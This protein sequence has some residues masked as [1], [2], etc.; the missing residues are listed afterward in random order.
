MYHSLLYFNNSSFVFLQ[1]I[2]F[3]YTSQNDLRHKSLQ[4]TK[5]YIFLMLVDIER[6]NL[7]LDRVKIT[8]AI[9]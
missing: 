5:S 1:G 9:R 7:S 4:E 2:F 6:L 3:Q 8:T